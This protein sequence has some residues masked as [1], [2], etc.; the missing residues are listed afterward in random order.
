MSET[1]LTLVKN[2]K[3]SIQSMTGY[4]SVLLPTQAGAI[5][6]ELRSVNSRFLDLQIRL[7]DEFRSQETFIRE[8]LMRF[9]QRGKI[10]CRLFWA[11]E[12]SQHQTTEIDTKTLSELATLE[13]EIKKHFP[14]ASSLSVQD[15]LNWPNIIKNK[16]LNANGPTQI[17]Q[18]ALEQ[19]TASL[20]QARQREGERLANILTEKID[21]MRQL[22]LEF[23][24]K[25]P[26]AILAYSN[27]LSQRLSEAM[28]KAIETSGAKVCGN[29]LQERIRQEIAL[30][31]I[32]MDIN[33]EIDRLHLHLKEFQSI[34]KNGGAVGKRLDFLTQELN[35]E[36]NTLGA[37]SSIVEQTQTSLDLKV[38]IEQVREQIQ[39]IE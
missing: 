20:V 7:C 32:K 12:E 36:A 28:H 30:H 14:Q 33:E 8:Y 18:T 1:H 31:S 26:E 37:K 15:I 35:R 29:E 2:T 19:A 11:Q 23:Y 4:A 3:T 6:L 22:L 10:E 39:N 16:H 13:H 24:P 17:T 5:H 21:A 9:F 34:L 27:K 38:L 25:L